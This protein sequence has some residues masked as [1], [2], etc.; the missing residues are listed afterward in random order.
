MACLGA[1]CFW[2]E[3]KTPRHAAALG[4]LQSSG[5][6]HII[7]SIIKYAA[8][9]LAAGVII[10]AA[11]RFARAQTPQDSAIFWPS[12]QELVAKAQIGGK[13]QIPGGGENEKRFYELLDKA[14]SK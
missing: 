2:L 4:F 1:G 8:L 7:K 5:K 3:P 13:V 10:I 12:E 6:K 11:S 9:P 14:N